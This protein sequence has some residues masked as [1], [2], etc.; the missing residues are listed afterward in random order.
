ME[1]TF[2]GS[3]KNGRKFT[4]D[5]FS[6]NE[7]AWFEFIQPLKN[8]KEPKAFLEIGCF[9]GMA[10]CWLLDNVLNPNDTI[11]VVDTFEGSPEF[12]VMGVNSSD[13]LK[14]FSQNINFDARVKT[15]IGKSQDI[16]LKLGNQEIFDFIYIDGSHKAKDVM[17]DAVLAWRLLKVGGILVFD[18]YEWVNPKGGDFYD[19]PKPAIN[20]FLHLYKN[21]MSILFQGY[22]V[23]L[24]KRG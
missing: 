3:N 24:Q 13:I 8:K 23:I 17:T 12:E 2:A 14:R 18:D 4:Q 9:E 22:Q 16:L 6:H 10:T 20:Y 19:Q 7:E 5:W 11:D 1:V 21:E 15:H